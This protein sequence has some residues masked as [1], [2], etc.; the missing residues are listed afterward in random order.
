MRR[1]YMHAHALYTCIGTST[2]ELDLLP[3]CSRGRAFPSI[4]MHRRV[5]LTPAE[6]PRS[7]HWGACIYITYMHYIHTLYTCIGIIYMHTQYMHAYALYTCI[8]TST[9]E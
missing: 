2:G 3:P 7:P 1:H 5:R 6:A 9:G 4:R 8:G